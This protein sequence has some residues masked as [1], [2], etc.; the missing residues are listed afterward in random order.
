MHQVSSSRTSPTPEN[1]GIYNIVSTRIATSQHFHLICTKSC[2]RVMSKMVTLHP[3]SQQET[4]FIHSVKDTKK[5]QGGLCKPKQAL[6]RTAYSVSVHT[7]RLSGDC[8]HMLKRVK[9]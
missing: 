4:I 2:T 9:C 1:K 5:T 7:G 6:G 8:V 3:D